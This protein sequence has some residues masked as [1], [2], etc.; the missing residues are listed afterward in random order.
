MH[1]CGRLLQFGSPRDNGLSPFNLAVDDRRIRGSKRQFET[2][3]FRTTPSNDTACIWDFDEISNQMSDEFMNEQQARKETHREIDAN[4][5]QATGSSSRVDVRDAPVAREQD[6]A[7]AWT[8]WTADERVVVETSIPPS[9]VR[10]SVTLANE[11]SDHRRSTTPPWRDAGSSYGAQEWP[12]WY[13]TNDAGG[14]Y[15][16]SSCS[17]SSPWWNNGGWHSGW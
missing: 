11:L 4:R 12:Q 3:R 15:N 7:S 9:H 8:D 16:N 1:H 10:V 14:Y 13:P 17:A 5:S 6:S 2:Q